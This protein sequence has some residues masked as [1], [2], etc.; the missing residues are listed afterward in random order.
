MPK[1]RLLLLSREG[2]CL[3][4]ELEEDLLAEFGPQA[5]ELER[6]DVDARADWQERYGRSIPVLLGEGGELLSETRLDA[7]RVASVLGR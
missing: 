5:F 6:A 2:C 3:C 7:A 1:P 4:D